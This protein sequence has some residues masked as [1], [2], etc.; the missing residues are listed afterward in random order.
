MPA[1]TF[2]IWQRVNLKGISE[3]NIH[4]MIVSKPGA[5]TILLHNNYQTRAYQVTRAGNTIRTPVD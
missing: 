2:E 3:S 4:E 5:L 1:S